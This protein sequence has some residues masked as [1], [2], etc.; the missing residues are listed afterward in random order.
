[1]KQR[2]KRINLAQIIEFKKNFESKALNTVCQSAKCPNIG[3]C[4]RNKIATFMI[5]GEYCTRECSFCAVGKY[6]TE[7]IDVSEPTKVAKAIKDLRLSYSVITSVTRDDLPDGGAEH[8]AKTINEIKTLLPGNKVEVLVP[9]FLG[10]TN[11][12]D[13]VLNA[14]PDVFSHNL[15]TVP[16]LYDVV[17]KGS[18]Y[19]RSL[20]VLEHAKSKDF[21]VKTG[22][23]LGLGETK[24]QIFETIKDIKN[25]NVDALI[26]GQ[27]LAPTLK[28]FS[29]IKEYTKEEFKMFENFAIS[30]KIKQVISGRYARSSY[31]AEANFKKF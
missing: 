31:L 7:F 1:M 8:F 14:K 6:D 22:I 16:T 20:S 2:K 19:Y 26:I 15:E 23:M 5:L 30:L 12:I 11:S 24:A 25:I 17:R 9:D 28:H 3:E 29:V 4:Y 10:N 27:Y 18:D 13:I 21:R